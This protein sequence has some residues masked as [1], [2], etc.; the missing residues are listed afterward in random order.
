MTETTWLWIGAIGML[1]GSAILFLTGSSRTQD[2]EG[3]RISHGL[4]PLFAAI[5]Y[6]AMAAHQGE[7]ALSSGRVVL[8]ARYLDWSITTPVLL[9]GLSM[10]A[11]H[12]ARRR[13][14]L[15]A[16]L[17]A[18]DVVMIVT[19]L[20][21]A[22]SDEPVAKWTW[23]LTSCMAFLAVLVI[24]FGA[25]RIEAGQRDPERRAAYGRN[26]AVLTV[27]WLVYPIVVVLGPDGLQLWSATLATA[28]I[29]I[30]DLVAKVGYGL[31]AAAGS[32]RITD[33]DLGRGETAAAPV[34]SHSVP[35]G[36][37]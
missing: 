10:T 5:A 20:F 33:A 2:E 26:V 19:G 28:C 31:L 7:T 32:K 17:I 34:S 1:A 9:L 14:G 37:G 3:H 36:R 11:L 16:G 27:L 25:L 35:S 22:L 23:Y 8:Y 30:L 24:L 4:V 21:F 12:G 13:A 15:V 18:S 29:T 6:F